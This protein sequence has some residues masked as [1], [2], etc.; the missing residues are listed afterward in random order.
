M[1]G[2]GRLPSNIGTGYSIIT[3]QEKFFDDLGNVFISILESGAMTCLG[4][5]VN[6][7]YQD[8]DRTMKRVIVLV[9]I[10]L[11]SGCEYAA[12]ILQYHPC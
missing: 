6:Y 5:C 2:V 11:L 10:K 7:M 4:S 8:V 9:A 12:S 3:V 1:Q